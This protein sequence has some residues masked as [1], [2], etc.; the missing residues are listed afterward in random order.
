MTGPH[1][2]SEVVAEVDGQVHEEVDGAD[3]L[4]VEEERILRLELRRFGMGKGA[5]E[6]LDGSPDL[7]SQ[8]VARQASRRELF[9]PVS[10]V[11][12]L[13]EHGADE[14]TEI[15][16]EVEYERAGGVGDARRGLPRGGIVRVCFD[17]PT[18][19]DAF[20]LGWPTVNGFT[21]RAER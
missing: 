19:G 5:V 17:L 14:V 16:G 1:D 7:G 2:L 13:A 20:R 21:S 3:T 4:L 6:I 18:L 15:A 8:V 10:L 12:A 9:L 11:A